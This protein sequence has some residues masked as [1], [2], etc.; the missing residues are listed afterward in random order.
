MTEYL[1]P[2]PRRG[3]PRLA[4]IATAALG[5]GLESLPVARTVTDRRPEAVAKVAR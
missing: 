1:R 5:K 2:R 3:L 4:R